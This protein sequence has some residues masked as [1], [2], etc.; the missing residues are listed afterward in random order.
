MG[1]CVARGLAGLMHFQASFEVVSNTGVEGSIAALENIEGPLVQGFSP[2]RFPLFLFFES[3]EHSFVGGMHVLVRC[4]V[5]GVRRKHPWKET[6]YAVLRTHLL[7][8]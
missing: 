4:T 6:P 8:L 3:R 5:Y 1:A 7:N 2:A